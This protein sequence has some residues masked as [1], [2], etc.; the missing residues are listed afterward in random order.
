MK[1]IPQRTCIN[2][3]DKIDKNKLYRIVKTKD[4]EIFYDA[5]GR[6]NGRGAYICEK[7]TCIESIESSNLLNRVF[8]LEV[9]DEIKQKLKENIIRSKN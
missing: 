8:Q 9:N 6:S 5:S 2:C 1:K 7:E 3:K 4:G